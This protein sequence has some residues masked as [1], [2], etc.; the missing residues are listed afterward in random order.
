MI[1]VSVITVTYNSSNEIVNFLDSVMP[2]IQDISGELII[3]DNNSNDDTCEILKSYSSKYVEL[4]TQ[5]NV[6]NIGYSK[7]NNQGISLAKGQYYLFLNPDIVIP[8]GAIRK[9][10]KYISQTKG[11][12]AV[13]PQLRYP[14]GRIQR[15][16]RRFPS[17]KDIIYESFGFSHIFPN[18]TRFNGWKMNNFSF[19]EMK[20]V[21]QPAGAALMTD[22]KLINKL[23]GFDESFPMFFSDVDL[24]NKI[25][26]EEK[27]IIFNPNIFLIHLG[28]SSVLRNRLKMMVSSHRSFYKY[29][30]KYRRG[31][32]NNF[33]NSLTGLLLII[34]LIPRMF[35]GYPLSI[36]FGDR[37]DTL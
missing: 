1:P 11:V 28:G 19:N 32:L 8:T 5:F 21:D 34:G 6:E 4:K 20:P 9:L 10:F 7:A 23:G 3:T 22:A 2:E 29:F 35:I 33:Y 18:S 14:D 26:S 12:G 30:K 37:R 36:L 16:C 15:S 24:C 17:R 13:A 27:K 31:A 25:W